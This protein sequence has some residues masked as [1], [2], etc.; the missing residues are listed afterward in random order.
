MDVGKEVGLLVVLGVHGVEPAL[1][2]HQHD[3]LAF[4]AQLLEVDAVTVFAQHVVLLE[5]CGHLVQRLAVNDVVV[6][7]LV[8]AQGAVVH[9]DNAHFHIGACAVYRYA[10]GR[11]LHEVVAVA[12]D[13]GGTARA[14]H[15]KLHQ[16]AV[17]ASADHEGNLLPLALAVL[18]ADTY[19][20]LDGV[21][22]LIFHFFGRT[23]V[24]HGLVRR[25]I[26][27]LGAVHAAHHVCL[28]V[29]DIAH[30][31]LYLDGAAK[32]SRVLGEGLEVNRRL[33]T[34]HQLQGLACPTAGIPVHVLKGGGHTTVLPVRG[35]VLP[36]A[37]AGCCQLQAQVKGSLLHVDAALCHVDIEGIFGGTAHQLHRLRSLLRE[38]VGVGLGASW[39]AHGLHRAPVL[40]DGHCRRGHACIIHAVLELQL[41]ILPD[42][43][44]RGQVVGCGEDAT[45]LE[46][47]LRADQW[48]AAAGFEDVHVYALAPE[49]QRLA[50]FHLCYQLHRVSAHAQ[51]A[52]GN[53]EAAVGGAAPRHGRA[54]GL[55]AVHIQEH[56]LRTGALDGIGDDHAVRVVVAAAAKAVAQA[57]AAA[58]AQV[59]H[60]HTHVC[61][62]GLRVA[63]CRVGGGGLH[64]DIGRPHL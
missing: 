31:Q 8:I 3:A 34:V 28:L 20:L 5:Q 13:I 9:A 2:H 24:H 16:T 40:P 10:L 22:V 52:H 35:V 33:R 64:I 59:H 29:G 53:G 32:C 4:V 37:P 56:G 47:M 45:I 46:R 58:Q 12:V 38:A 23:S 50:G 30:L 11:V 6:H 43:Q 55:D 19:G 25:D 61:L 36:V 39:Y 1:T 63:G 42:L 54:V 44:S 62:L 48:C 57:V 14:V 41:L 7:F 51:S 18:S 15:I 60:A 27:A 21:A 49:R 26:E 17:G